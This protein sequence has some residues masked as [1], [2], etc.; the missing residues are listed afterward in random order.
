V[1]SKGNV[2]ETLRQTIVLEVIKLADGFSM[3]F[4]KM[5]VKDIV[6]E[7]ATTQ[8]KEET[9]HSLSAEML[10]CQPVSEVLPALTIKEE[11]AISL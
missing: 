4:P 2:I 5:S 6:E 8:A 7:L 10:E 1:G 9:T 3:G 11:M